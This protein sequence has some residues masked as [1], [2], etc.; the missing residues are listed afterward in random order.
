MSYVKQNTLIKVDTI[1]ITQFLG[2]AGLATFLPFYLH[3]QYFTGPI[4]NALLI[5]L[6]FLVGIR[7]ALLLCLIPS[8]MALSGGLIPP[9]L[10]PVVPFIMI[11]NVLFVLTIDFI[12]NNTKDNF[13][14]Y[15]LGIFAGSILKF[16][17]LLASVKIIVP[18]LSKQALAMKVAQMMSWPQLLTALAGGLIAWTFLKWLKR[19]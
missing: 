4:I 6:L 18:L 1:A 15:W 16:I 5:I 14:G 13:K 10:A 7:S 8:L 19:L 12:Y 2:I 3:I 11:S 17:F 9:I